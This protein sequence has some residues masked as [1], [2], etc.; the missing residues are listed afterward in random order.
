MSK[1]FRWRAL[2]VLAVLAG[3]I[4][5]V[6]ARPVRLGLDLQGGTQITLEA[7][8]TPRQKVD[9]DTAS[10]TRGATSRGSMRWAIS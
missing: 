1:A 7:Q 6:L 5:L 2:L 10:R 8:D 4:A 3:A 9:G